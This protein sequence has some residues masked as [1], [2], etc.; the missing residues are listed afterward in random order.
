MLI[1]VGLALII[2]LTLATGYFV[3]Q[4]FA[5]VAADRS[6]LAHQASEGDPAARRA[7]R[8][9]ERLSFTLSGAQLG[10]TVTVLLIGYLA[11]PYLGQ[12][13]VQLLSGDGTRIPETASLSIALILTLLFSTAVQMI[14]GE[15][16]PKNLAIARSNR[17]ARA[18][19]TS[20][21][22]YRAVTAPV[23]RLFDSASNRLLRLVGIEP[24]EELPEGATAEDLEQIIA[25]AQAQ[26]HLDAETSRLLERGLDF[27]GHTAAEAMMPR[28][29][30]TTVSA[31]QPLTEVVALLDRSGHSRFP[32]LGPEGVDDIV[33]VVGV[34][35]VLGV[36]PDRRAITTAGAVA[37]PP[38]LLPAA[39]PL[40]VVLDRL[41][42]G[43]RQLACVVDEYGGL[44]G[45]ITLEDVAEE[46]VGPISD[47][48]DPPE[49]VAAR[50]RDGTWLVPATLRIDEVADAT[51][52]E[53]PTSEHYDTLSGLVLRRLG[54]MARVGDEVEVVGVALRVVA[55][56]RQVPKTVRV[57]APPE[58]PR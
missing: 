47:E 52:V 57:Q 24:V 3:A 17:M 10:I 7:L 44:A 16:A 26:G 46:L 43:H 19:S 27:R 5:Y 11:E 42:R 41:R 15:L 9:T 38:L 53:L 30:V 36:P 33:G 54:R 28:V 35:D 55:V 45:I 18:L 58:V 56:H 2:G 1:L 14:I 23:V 8:V 32:V 22:A 4:E 13:L 37:V 20:T 50:Q 29:S 48:A 6:R 31:D 34:F 12:G 39:L 25:E 40:P 51:G 49:P 21:L